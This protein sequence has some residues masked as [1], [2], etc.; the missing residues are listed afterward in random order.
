MS[1]RAGAVGRHKDRVRNQARNHLGE[2]PRQ[3]DHI[4]WLSHLLF[5][6]ISSAFCGSVGCACGA[7]FEFT[8]AALAQNLRRLAKLVVWPPPTALAACVA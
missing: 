3:L 7:Q 6:H 8:L 2:P 5:S 1:R 4:F